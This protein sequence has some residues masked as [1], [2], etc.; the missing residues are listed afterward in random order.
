MA[1]PD[2]GTEEPGTGGHLVFPKTMENEGSVVTDF[3]QKS[4]IVIVVQHAGPRRLM[5]GFSIA[6]EVLGVG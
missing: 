6:A 2:L 3:P 5:S 4:Y 1:S